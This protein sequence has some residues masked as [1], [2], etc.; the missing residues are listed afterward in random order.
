MKIDRKYFFLGFILLIT[1]V[2]YWPVFQNHS[3]VWDDDGYITNNLLIKS[4]HLKEIFTS[5]VMGNYHPFT[6][7]VLAVEYFLF[8]LDATGYHI[9]NLILHLLNV[10]LVYLAVHQLSRKPDVALIAALLFGI[11]PI[12][13]ESVAWASGLKD[14]LF[15]F[16]FLSSWILYL[17]YIISSNR[18]FY[19]ISLFLFLLSLLSKAMAVSLP[20]VLL[21]TDFYRGRKMSR[22]V[23][24]DKIPF[25]FLAFLFGILAVV[26]QKSSGNIS[27]LGFSVPQ[28]LSFACYGFADYLVKLVLPFKLS[29][30]YPYPVSHPDAFPV[31][32][33]TY[34]LVIILFASL[35]Y[36]AYRNNRKIFFGMV[37]F[38]IT[39]FLVLQWLPVG[40]AIMADRYCYLSSIG[41]FFLAGE[42]IIFLRNS[43]L[44]WTAIILLIVLTVF[45]AGKTY[46]RTSVWKNDITLWSD[47]MAKFPK[48]P[49]SYMNRGIALAK[50]NKS[51]KAA[52]D[53]TKA[54]ELDTQYS[55]AYFNRGNIYLKEQHPD[56]ALQ[57]F[58]KA[59]ELNPGYSQAYFNRGN[60]Y[61]DTEEFDKALQDYSRAIRLNPGEFQVYTNRG[62]VF[63]MKKE[64]KNAITDF[65]KAISLNPK[66][67]DAWFNRGNALN[68]ERRYDEAINSFS[69]TIALRPQDAEAYYYRGLTAYYSGSRD[70]AVGDFRKAA[71]LGYKPAEDFL[72][73]LSNQP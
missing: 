45:F 27:V 42:G 68:M 73:I 34:F 28:Q 71:G 40:K 37:F 41:I 61:T 53:F 6:V 30:F 5:N 31:F 64:Y 59:I 19:Y 10:L 23:W 52:D 35:M 8:G 38:A 24:M 70:A 67:A 14:L 58:N 33:Y 32:W 49:V 63:S 44:K 16:F 60:I 26:T 56:L 39:I 25:L 50:L 21:L 48:A 11:H 9:V 1:L 15:V 51:D 36:Y 13:V 43:K 7:L 72:R 17:K 69:K 18:Y 55:K 62:I 57:D 66:D 4:F 20:L 12:H 29:A 22:S 3:F 65:D 2:S 54:I 46:I 47:V